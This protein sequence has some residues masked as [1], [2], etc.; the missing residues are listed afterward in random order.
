MFWREA[1]AEIHH[2]KALLREAHA[3]E[4]IKILVAVHVGSA[5][6]THD[7]GQRRLGPDGIIDIQQLLR[8]NRAG[9][10]CRT[11][12]IS[13]TTRICLIGRVS[14]ICQICDPHYILRRQEAAVS[15]VIVFLKGLPDAQGK[16]FFRVHVRSHTG[17]ARGNSGSRSAN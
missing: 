16:Q 3:I 15:F 14:R 17:S 13:R 12:R 8:I 4:L 2:R 9:L 7:D 5:V 1:V 11:G 10:V 6:H